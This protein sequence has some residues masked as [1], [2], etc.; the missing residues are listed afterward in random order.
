[1][2]QPVENPL[3][4]RNHLGIAPQVVERVDLALHG[5]YKGIHAVDAARAVEMA[6]GLVEFP[7][8]LVHLSQVRHHQSDVGLG[9]PAF[10]LLAL[11]LTEFGFL[12]SPMQVLLVVGLGTTGGDEHVEDVHLLCRLVSHGVVV[13]QGFADED[14]RVLVL[15]HKRLAVDLGANELGAIVADV[16]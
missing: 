8:S 15:L 2:V 9:A 7:E 3:G 1:M 16:A 13:E 11:L 5:D 14:G 6:D 10:G 12:H 4:Q